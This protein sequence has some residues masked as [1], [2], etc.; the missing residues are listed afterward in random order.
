MR[1]G[2]VLAVIV[3]TGFL[4]AAYYLL[5]LSALLLNFRNILK[6]DIATKILF[7][8]SQLVHVVFVIGL[9][10]GVYSEK[11][12]NGGVQLFFIGAINS[13]VYLLVFLLWPV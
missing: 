1:K 5:Y 2:D 7:A 12:F 4:L 10:V 13:Y 8:T 3:L 11:Y 9:F 6:Q